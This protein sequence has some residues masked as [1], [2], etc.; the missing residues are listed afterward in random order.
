MKCTTHSCSTE[1]E[2]VSPRCLDDQL[3][4]PCGVHHIRLAV[5]VVYCLLYLLLVVVDIDKVLLPVLHIGPETEGDA[6]HTSH[7]NCEHSCKHLLQE[8]L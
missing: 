3:P 8:M 5:G 1:V 4:P 7:G 6:P 2:C